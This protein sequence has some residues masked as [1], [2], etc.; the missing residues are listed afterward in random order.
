MANPFATGGKFSRQG[1]R[2][3]ILWAGVSLLA[4]GFLLGA[5]K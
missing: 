4:I 1:G 3:L 2:L 5:T